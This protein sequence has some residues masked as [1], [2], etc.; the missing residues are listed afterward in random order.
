MHTLHPS[1][2]ASLHPIFF[3]FFFLLALCVITPCL[4]NKPGALN[5]QEENNPD[6]VIELILAQ[7]SSSSRKAVLQTGG[8]GFEGL[9][10]YCYCI[11][12]NVGSSIS[13]PLLLQFSPLL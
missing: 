6:D 1:H 5:A 8:D 10:I 11:M 2:L 4:K 12:G 7:A 9:I 13:E 3:S